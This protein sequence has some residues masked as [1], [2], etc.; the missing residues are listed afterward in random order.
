MPRRNTSVFAVSKATSVLT[1]HVTALPRFRFAEPSGHHGRG[2][3]GPGGDAA[4]RVHG[5]GAAPRQD[6][7]RAARRR[8]QGETRHLVVRTPSFKMCDKGGA[9]GVGGGGC[10][11]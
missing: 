7:R 8:R 6:G 2:P 1:E 11:A 4:L 5:Q 3:R 9:E 10:M